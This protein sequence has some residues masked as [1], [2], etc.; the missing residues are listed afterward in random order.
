MLVKR[1]RS[2]QEGGGGVGGGG[3]G[4]GG[5]DWPCFVMLSSAVYLPGVSKKL[6]NLI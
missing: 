4:G 2:P 3:G 5:G 6:R 1:D